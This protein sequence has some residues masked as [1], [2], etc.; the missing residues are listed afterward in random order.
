MAPPISPLRVQYG[1]AVAL[2]P[3]AIR[4]PLCSAYFAPSGSIRLRS[5]AMCSFHCAHTHGFFLG[6]HSRAPR[7]L[8][9]LPAPY[10]R[11]NKNGWARSPRG[12]APLTPGCVLA[13]CQGASFPRQ[14]CHICLR[15]MF[16]PPRHLWR[17]GGRQA[18]GE[19]KRPPRRASI[20][21]RH[22]YARNAGVHSPS[23][24]IRPQRGRP[25]PLS[26]YGEGVAD[27]PGERS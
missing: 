4:A 19:V 14:I 16:I 10:G 3:M 18:G 12:C 26:I 21:P 27:R 20:P 25:F 8:C 13:P 9:Y 2:L 24:H 15:Q 5:R 11:G 17:G 23:P 22:T 6:A 7:A 1:F